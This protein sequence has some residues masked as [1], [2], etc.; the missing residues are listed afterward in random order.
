MKLSNLEIKTKQ[1]YINR[2]VGNEVK[3]ETLTTEEAIK[4][5][6]NSQVLETY[7]E[8]EDITIIIIQ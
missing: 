2:I 3:T 1:V 7:K 5:Y 8:N 6:G 4:K